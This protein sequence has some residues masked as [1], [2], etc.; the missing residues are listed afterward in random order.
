[1]DNQELPLELVDNP[2]ITWP[3]EAYGEAGLAHGAL[4]FSAGGINER[5]C[6]S[7]DE[8]FLEMTGARIRLWSRIR[9]L[10]AAGDDMATYL[11]GAIRSPWGLLGGD[12][13]ESNP[14]L[15]HKPPAE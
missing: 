14:L 12:V 5:R 9:Q 10:A 3:C 7:P 4:C 11:E 8:C 15:R 2:G 6:T 1:M 13:V